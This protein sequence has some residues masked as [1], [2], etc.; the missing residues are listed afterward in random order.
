MDLFDQFGMLSLS[1][2]TSLDAVPASVDELKA[3]KQWYTEQ[4]RGSVPTARATRKANEAAAAKASGGN[5]KA[6][7]GNRGGKNKGNFDISNDS[8][9]VPL[10]LGSSTGSSANA[11]W[12]QKLDE[13]S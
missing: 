10:G 9:F 11:S 1:P 6:K 4:P 8:E 7:G 3:K 5:G 13:A 12:G 2:P